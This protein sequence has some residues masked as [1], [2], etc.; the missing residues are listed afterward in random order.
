MA[1]S[2]PLIAT[3]YLTKYTYSITMCS[4]LPDI[5]HAGRYLIIE[6]HVVNRKELVREVQE[7][8]YGID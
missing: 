2:A 6:C 7:V 5:R 8:E 4:I 1:S 3:P